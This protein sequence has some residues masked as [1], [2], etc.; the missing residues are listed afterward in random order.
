MSFKR[1]QLF[2]FSLVC[3][4]RNKYL[5]VSRKRE[6]KQPIMVV[7]AWRWAK[8]NKWI[9]RTRTSQ[10]RTLRAS[11]VVGRYIVSS[12][13]QRCCEP[14]HCTRCCFPCS[15]LSLDVFFFSSCRVCH[16]QEGA[17]DRLSPRVRA[18][19]HWWIQ[20]EL[21]LPVWVRTDSWP[22]WPSK[23]KGWMFPVCLEESLTSKS[24]QTVRLWFD[25]S[26]FVGESWE[27]CPK[28]L[29][30]TYQLQVLLFTMWY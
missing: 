10:W 13:T 2:V 11:C 16:C 9:V 23:I 12:V 8:L 26:R 1:R 30:H 6:E 19:L 14:C 21:R 7:M 24:K 20:G 22:L 3:K 28:T 18:E 25:V 29:A 27:S 15:L 5:K 17:S 4:L